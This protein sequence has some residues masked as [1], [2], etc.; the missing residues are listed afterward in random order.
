MLGC[1]AFT[2]VAGRRPG[3]TS[4]CTVR[5]GTRSR[6][7]TI[8]Y[9][10]LY[11]KLAI[12]RSGTTFPSRSGI[13][14]D[15]IDSSDVLSL[16]S[17]RMSTLIR[18]MLLRTCVIVLPDT[19]PYRASDTSWE[20][21]PSCRAWSWSIRTRMT[22]AG[23]AQ[24]KLMWRIPVIASSCSATFSAMSCAREVRSAHAVFDW[25]AHGRPKLERIDACDH[26]GESHCDRLLQTRAHLVTLL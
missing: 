10:W 22:R 11:S 12:W 1:T 2:A 24:S 6:R 15:R 8:G 23:S 13:C 21:S 16:C 4:A 7:H 25:P 17:A 19:T 5:V 14:S 3:T 9:S 18:Y 26:R 20:L